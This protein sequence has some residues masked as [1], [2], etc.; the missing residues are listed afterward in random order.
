MSLSLVK[1]AKFTNYMSRKP[2][3][4]ASKKFK[5]IYPLYCDTVSKK[6][7]IGKKLR[8]T[9]QTYLNIKQLEINKSSD[10][11]WNRHLNSAGHTK[12]RV[13][14]T[15]F[16]TDQGVSGGIISH[17]FPVIDKE[18]REKVERWE[19]WV[20]VMLGAPDG[21]STVK[22]FRSLKSLGRNLASIVICAKDKGRVKA[23]RDTFK[24]IKEADKQ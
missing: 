15:C 5:K 17:F 20:W 8:N 10:P 21:K 11:N 22:A 4:Y 23:M 1:V 16:W 13:K 3:F 18:T 6:V 12:I 19:T 14:K 9:T 2:P 7:H 24:A